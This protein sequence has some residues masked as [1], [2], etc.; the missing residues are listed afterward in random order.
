MNFKTTKDCT[1][2]L[3]TVQTV[4]D[5]KH[6]HQ[7]RTHNKLNIYMIYLLKSSTVFSPI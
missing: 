4:D 2:S 1:L 3:S 7:S 5:S 6:N